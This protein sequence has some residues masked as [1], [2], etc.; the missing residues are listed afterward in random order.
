MIN[1]SIKLFREKKVELTQLNCGYN[2]FNLS[3]INTDYNVCAHFKWQYYCI[4]T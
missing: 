1:S 2:W 4:M 3:V